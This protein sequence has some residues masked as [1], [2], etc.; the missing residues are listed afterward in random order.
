MG[1][2][3]YGWLQVEKATSKAAQRKSK[4]GVG[5]RRVGL[6]FRR[7]RRLAGNVRRFRFLSFLRFSVSF[8]F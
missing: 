5:R 7:A 4:S 3:F 6:G 1:R 2:L 8:V